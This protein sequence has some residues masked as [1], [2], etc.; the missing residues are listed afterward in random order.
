M[1][2]RAGRLA[3]LTEPDLPDEHGQPRGQKVDRHAGDDLIASEGDRGKAVNQRK[4]GC[5]NDAEQEAEIDLARFAPISE[6]AFHSKP[7]RH[8]VGRRVGESGGDEGCH[9]HFAFE[10]DIKDPRTLGIEPRKAGEQE[11]R[12]EAQGAVE[13]LK[14]QIK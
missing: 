1:P 10:A 2:V 4:Q 5:R 12:R 3:T 7:A 8:G 9:Q 13:Q 6:R 11:R 14:E